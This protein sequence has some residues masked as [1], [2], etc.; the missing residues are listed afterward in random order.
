M[1]TPLRLLI[2]ED[3]PA[4]AELMVM[5]LTRAGFAP[6]WHR[7]ETDLE[8]TTA[9]G[10]EIELILADYQLP[11]YDALRALQ[12]VQQS[13]IKAPFLIV[14]GNIGEELA[15]AAM[16][17][18]A[19]D[20]VIKDR[21]TRLGQAALHALEQARL[22]EA[23]R[24]NE[25][26]SLRIVTAAKDLS[27]VVP[28]YE[29][30]G[31]LAAQLAITPEQTAA[32]EAA[33]APVREYL[34]T[35]ANELLSA[36]SQYESPVPLVP[37]PDSLDVDRARPCWRRSRIPSACSSKPSVPS[38]PRCWA[39]CA[40]AWRPCCERRARPLEGA[41]PRPSSAPVRFRRF[42]LNPSRLLPK[43]TGTKSWG[44]EL[45]ASR[46]FPEQEWR[47]PCPAS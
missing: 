20:F 7:V 41:G 40:Y 39:S 36:F 27:Q 44:S 31:A 45:A 30:L 24:R 8:F 13:G 37:A 17:Q 15:V 34:D 1:P 46:G 29:R 3:N 5:H 35:R 42:L 16:Q 14:S 2:L 47:F 22:R 9:L 10:P 6:R 43:T 18:G 21:M 12:R 25:E 4:D 23:L 26:L 33:E 38:N 32:V 11:N 19:A 28:H